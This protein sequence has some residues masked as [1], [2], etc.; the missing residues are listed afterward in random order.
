MAES[1]RWKSGNIISFTEDVP[2]EESDRLSIR[3]LGSGQEVGRSC[4]MLEFKG[5]KVMLDCGIHPGLSGMDALPF[6]DHI[7][8]EEIDLLLVSHFHLDH[9]GALPWFLQR[10]TFRGRCFM[11]HASKA[12]YRWL[13]SDY[14]KV[15][16]ISATGDQ[17]LYSEADLESSM[18]RIETL[19]FHE[20]KDVNGVRFWAYHAGHVL[21][22]AMFMIEIAGVKILYTGDFSREEDR[23]LMKAEIP[24]IRPDILIMES[25]YGTHIHEKREERENRF[26][27][28]VHDI[29]TR[30]GRCLIPVFALGR[31]Q[32][33]LLILDEFWQ[34]HPE[35]HEI[36]IYY[37]S[38][39]AKKCMAV[40]QT[41]INAMNET[42]RKQIAVSN[43]FQFKHITSLRRLDHF[44]DL[45]PCVIMASPGM[46][47]T[48][49]SRALFEMWCTDSKNG[50]I[51]AGYCV[52]GTLAK[53]VLSEPEEITTLS[54]TK[55]P[56][57]MSID[58]VSFS[59]HADYR[60]IS[61]FVRA[62]KPPEIILVHGEVNEMTRLKVALNREYEDDPETKIRI[63]TPKN[64]QEVM[65]HFH[66]EKMAKVMGK[67]AEAPPT[68]GHQVSGVIVKKNFTYHILHP[69]D[70]HKYTNLTQS[71]VIQ[72]QCM[73]Y[74]KGSFDLLHQLL[75]QLSG[76]TLLL[77][78]DKAANGMIL[79][80]SLRVYDA[81]TVEYEPGMITLEWEA[82]PAHDMYAD[83]ILVTILQVETS[84]SEEEKL[85][86][87]SDEVVPTRIRPERFKQCLIETLQDMY[88]SE[89][90]PKVFGEDEIPITVDD[91]EA[92][93]NLKDMK[94]NCDSDLEL[95]S[96]LQVTVSNLYH[97]LMPGEIK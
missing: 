23:H 8:A 35:L 28:V 67:L 3:P 62:L 44:D 83:G 61:E 43:P 30:G 72:R 57:R 13:L 55:L 40:Y 32:E 31:A 41:Y 42:I 56:L 4:H 46:M 91:K 21:G 93:L 77:R 1:A 97:A 11:T 73:T 51:I 27:G 7:D 33:L 89:C 6:V 37:A 45:G 92:V 95:E 39:L 12:I 75:N 52:E 54:G 64:I 81:V 86:L 94:V 76:S 49:L 68:E 36:P 65:L 90:V 69:D 38:S 34:E 10:T 50:V 82:S 22:A 15:S 66:G 26:T 25:T 79:R 5:K 85:M 87:A 47:Q 20:E 80:A 29:V 60:Q 59:A 53:T 58:Y 24:S 17:L 74:K 16:D 63:H 18:D 19:N 14:I 48:G 70:L 96:L 71:R 78:R 84:L 2:A 9:C 88:G